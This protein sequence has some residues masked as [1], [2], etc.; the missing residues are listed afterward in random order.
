[1]RPAARTLDILLKGDNVDAAATL[2]MLLEVSDDQVTIAHLAHAALEAAAGRSFDACLLD[3]GLPE[4]DGNA[5]ARRLRSDLLNH[6]S[7]LVT[8]TG[9][10]QENDRQNSANAGFD[11]HFVKPVDSARLL[12]LLLAIG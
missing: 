6:A 8:I 10:G 2:G 7:V 9:Y 11:D 1:M 12:Q 3:I 4:M 5:L